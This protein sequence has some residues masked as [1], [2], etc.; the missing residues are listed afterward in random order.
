V[1]PLESRQMTQARVARRSIATR[2]LILILVAAAVAVPVVAFALTTDLSGGR[3]TDGA[4]ASA[5]VIGLNPLVGKPAP[6]VDLQ[7]LDGSRVSLAA[8]RGRPVIVNFWASWCIPCKAEFPLF[9][10]ARAAHRTDGL[11]ILGV[12]HDDSA[13]AARSFM[14]AEGATWPALI[15]HGDAVARAYGVNA[16][17]I[18]FYVDRGGLVRAVSYGPPPSGALDDQLSKI[19]GS[20]ASP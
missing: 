5:V 20:G 16:L 6:T 18:S 15:D 10:T 14:R 17:P 8:L 9:V 19:L 11:E 7:A 2:R 4:T 13:D 12:I 1:E 3:P